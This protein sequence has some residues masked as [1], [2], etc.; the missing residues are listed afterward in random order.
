M[1]VVE[2]TAPAVNPQFSRDPRD[3]VDPRT[4]GL[5][6][7]GQGLRRRGWLMRRMLL[8]GDLIGLISAFAIA[9]VFLASHAGGSGGFSDSSEILLFAA[10]LPGW[11]VVAKLYSLYDRDDSRADHSTVD[12]F[13]AVFHFLT[14]CTWLFFAFMW[15]SGVGDPDLSKLIGFWAIGIAFV[16]IGRAAARA[17]CRRS[18]SFLQNTIIVGAGDVGQLVAR[19]FLQHPEYGINLVGFID[20]LPKE[21]NDDLGHLTDLGTISDLP[22]LVELLDVERVVIAFSNESHDQMLELVRSLKD[23]DVQIDIVPRLF[24]IVGPGVEMHTVEGL[25]LVGLRSL[26][27]SRSS[28]FL[29]RSLDLFF[30]SLALVVLSPLLL[31]V[32]LLIKLDSRGPVL[33]RQVRQGCKEETFRIFKFRT[34]NID[35]E[36]QK[37]GV[38]HL[39]MHRRNGGDDRM[40]KIRQDPRITRVGG[41]L[42]RYSL[43]E[44]PQLLNVVRGEMSLVGPRPLILEEDRFVREWARE[45]LAIKPGVTGPWQVLGRNHIPFGEMV[46]LDYLYVTNWSM[47][48]DLKWLFRTVPA[49]LRTEAY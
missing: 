33:F 8:A 46:R 10:S 39:N 30:A 1:T 49:L 26:K 13:L 36:E 6:D 23:L 41:F 19:K 3:L 34:M 4:R 29:K 40:F 32:A 47:A 44:L 42:R 37:E 12:E 48:N 16:S 31:V 5:L 14:V 22:D 27:L 25:P 45:R 43:D 9:H 21:R 18:V 15:V 24:E 20:A 17:L 35:A 38:A 28:R 7:R 11:I 2:T